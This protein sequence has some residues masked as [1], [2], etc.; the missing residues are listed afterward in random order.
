MNTN[1]AKEQYNSMSFFYDVLYANYDVSEFGNEF[2]KEH[3]K[4]LATLSENAKILDSSCGKGVQAVALKEQGFDI[5][6]TDIS[7]EMIHLT[8]SYAEDNNLSIPT[9][10]LAWNELPHEF[11]NIF[12]IV[13]C[14]GNSISHSLGKG[15]M[16]NNLSSFYNVIKDDGKVV[17]HTRNW[18]KILKDNKRYQSLPVR[19]YN[20]RKYIPMYIW[21]LSGFNQKS[22][23]DILF[24]EIRED[25][26][27]SHT[28]FRLDFVPFSH[29]DLIDRLKTTGFEISYDN[30]NEKNDFYYVV[31]GK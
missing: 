24:I 10:C 26:T 20:N 4:L 8:E 29:I 7:K 27:T 25:E 9:K 22:Y 28:S 11:D 21:N 19:E 17:I 18:E 1:P 31:A 13:F 6:A 3:E 2:I 5:T 12:D 30:Y 15:D 14:W 23:V 16:I